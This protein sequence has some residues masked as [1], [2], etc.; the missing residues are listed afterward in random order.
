MLRA[1]TFCFL[2]VTLYVLVI[3]W[4]EFNYQFLTLNMYHY[5]KEVELYIGDTSVPYSYFMK[6]LDKRFTQKYSDAMKKKNVAKTYLHISKLQENYNLKRYDFALP[7]L[8]TILYENGVT[9]SQLKLVSFQIEK[10]SYNLRPDIYHALRFNNV[11]LILTIDHG[12]RSCKLNRIANQIGYVLVDEPLIHLCA[13]NYFSD[14]LERTLVH[15]FLHLL[16][17][18]YFLEKYGDFFV[19]E[20]H[21]LYQA[22]S[23]LQSNFQNN[24][25]DYRMVNSIEMMAE[26]CT[27]Y[28]FDTAI[29]NEWLELCSKIFKTKQSM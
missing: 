29:P 1:T 26:V 6:Y 23:I 2:S 9:V 12:F 4:I 5:A 13:I 10:L 24:K 21:K 16:Q 22:S 11:S 28:Y 20:S 17:S 15:E 3:K 14:V 7:W 27:D 18:E 8:D 25:M 19:S